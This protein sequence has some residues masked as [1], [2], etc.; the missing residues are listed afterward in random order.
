MKGKE[1]FSIKHLC[2]FISLLRKTFY[3]SSA[4]KQ[5]SVDGKVWPI[6]FGPHAVESFL[7]RYSKPLH[8]Q[9]IHCLLQNPK[10]YYCVY[11]SLPMD[12]IQNQVNSHYIIIP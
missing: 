10:F 5:A 6:L 11:I 4:H 12:H 7:R 8:G 3:D 9:E 1:W 2:N